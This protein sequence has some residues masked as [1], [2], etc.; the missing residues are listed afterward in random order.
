MIRNSATDWGAI[1]KFL[2]WAGAALIVALLAHGWWMV[3][4]P[5][6]DARFANYSW[7]ASIGY[8]TLVLLVIRIAWRWTNVVPALPSGAAR[9]ERASAALGHWGLYALTL[10]AS[11]SGWA[12]AGT[13]RRPLDASLLGLFPVPALVSSQDRTLH[14]QLESAHSVLAWVLLAL[15]FVHIAAATYHHIVK[16]NDV[17]QRMLPFGCKRIE[18]S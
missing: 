13:F 17:M 18:R 12:L 4:V 11:F 1:A 14:E 5:A 9:W 7:H 16:K 2:H 3:E 10:C 15:I 8:A 6:R